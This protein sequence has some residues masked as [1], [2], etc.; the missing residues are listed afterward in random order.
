VT[1]ILGVGAAGRNI[2]RTF[3]SAGARGYGGSLSG[4]VAK[5]LTVT[6]ANDDGWVDVLTSES[7]VNALFGG[8]GGRLSYVVPLTKIAQA[9]KIA[10]ADMDSD[11]VGDLVMAGGGNVFLYTGGGVR[12]VGNGSFNGAYVFFAGDAFEAVSADFDSDGRQDIVTTANSSGNATIFR[13]ML[14]SLGQASFVTSEVLPVGP[15]PEG[16]ET[17]DFNNDDIPDIVLVGGSVPTAALRVLPGHGANGR[18][19]GTFSPTVSFSTGNKTP[20]RMQTADFDENGAPDVAVELLAASQIGIFLANGPASF[21]AITTVNTDPTP[22]GIAI[23]DFNSDDILDLAVATVT[24]GKIDLI[25]GA[26]ANG[27][28]NGTFGVAA[29]IANCVGANGLTTGDFNRDGIL[30]LAA[31]CPQE[32]NGV[33]GNGL[34]RILLGGGANGVANGTFSLGQ[35]IVLP[36]P[37]VVITGDYNRDGIL[38]LACTRPAGITIL[39]GDGANGRGAGTFTAGSQVFIGVN[40]RGLSSSDVDGDGILD[41]IGSRPGLGGGVGA[42]FGLGTY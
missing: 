11:G 32:P 30:D 29:Q 36:G 19:D 33:S 9:R 26:G 28:G 20:W 10:F 15:G 13:G 8:P 40:L 18:G 39:L 22:E 2:S 7:T 31:S 23:G 27:K 41:L 6:D 17:G 34:I 38:D 42:F 5:V 35:G 4:S 21:A 12:G 37:E 24:N 16:I 1:T 3:D 14:D 25:L